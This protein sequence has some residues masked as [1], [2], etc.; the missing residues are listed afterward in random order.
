MTLLH[1]LLIVAHLL[2]MA[3]IIGP[4]LVHF[5]RGIIAPAQLWGA[6]AQLLTGLMLVGFLESGLIEPDEPVDHAKVGVK[7][8]VA[9][10]IIASAETRRRRE[11]GKAAH[12]M[13]GLAVLNVVIAVLWR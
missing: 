7:C 6:R 13:V 10:A 9:L 3:A 4:W 1:R 8:L 5:R 2:G 11:A 12:V